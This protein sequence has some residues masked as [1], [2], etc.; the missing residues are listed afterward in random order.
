MAPRAIIVAT[1][2]GA[3]AKLVER[4]EDNDLVLRRI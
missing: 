3:M 2:V 1:M 4:T